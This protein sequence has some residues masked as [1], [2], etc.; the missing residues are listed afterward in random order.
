M[1]ID[2]SLEKTPAYKESAPV[3]DEAAE[4]KSLAAEVLN[5]D[6]DDETQARTLIQKL[7]DIFRTREADRK[8]AAVDVRKQLNDKYEEIKKNLIERF[9]ELTKSVE[10]FTKNTQEAVQDTAGKATGFLGGLFEKFTMPKWAKD[11]MGT[12]NGTGEY[13]ARM[14]QRLYYGM[15]MGIDKWILSIPLVGGA[16]APLFGSTV[17]QAREALIDM[18]A[19]DGFNEAI[20]KLRANAQFKNLSV[21]WKPEVWAI[22]RQKYIAGMN[23]KSSARTFVMDRVMMEVTRKAVTNNLPKTME[24][25]FP[26]DQAVVSAP[27]APAATVAVPGQPTPINAAPGVVY[28]APTAPNDPAADPVSP[29]VAPATA[30]NRIEVN[31]KPYTFEVRADGSFLINNQ[32][33]RLQLEGASSLFANFAVKKIEV[34]PDQSIAFTLF[35]DKLIGSDKEMS[36]T[37]SP[38]V[39]KGI[40]GNIEAKKEIPFEVK[41]GDTPYKLALK[42][43]ST[44][45]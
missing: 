31:G 18:D 9:P 35:I 27:V 20:G 39:V 45:L 40:V 42:P 28:A 38:D 17:E 10:E 6:H 43:I 34:K 13:L 26:L 14:G 30:P 24:E 12:A 4:L 3:K 21:T 5:L 44:I 36:Q 1:A 37:L 29:T 8:N 22:W 33:W 25:I 41:D 16:L 15:L 23:A 11:F 32:P 7:T 19:E 2:N